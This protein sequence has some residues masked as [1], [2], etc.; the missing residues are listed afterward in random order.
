MDA[1]AREFVSAIADGTC[2]PACGCRPRCP[3]L[4]S[5]C[6]RALAHSAAVKP[7]VGRR[8]SRVLSGHAAIRLRRCAVHVRPRGRLGVLGTLAQLCAP[9][10]RR[11]RPKR[12]SARRLKGSGWPS[13]MYGVSKLCES[14]Y[15]RLLA[16]ELRPRSVAVNACCPGCERARTGSS[17]AARALGGAAQ[18]QAR[19]AAL[20]AGAGEGTGWMGAIGS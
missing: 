3:V 14:M 18:L 5:E 10:R 17:P 1:L 20:C 11:E 7:R 15:T 4:C 8:A 6:T 16:D 2:A 13:S 19:P 9:P 12:R